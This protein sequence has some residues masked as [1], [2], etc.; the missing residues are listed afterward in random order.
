MN[1]IVDFNAPI[2][3]GTEIVF[4]SPV[5]CSLVT[6]LLVNY[7]GGSQEFAFA[8]A[9]G[10][11]VGD[12]DHL[13]AENVVVKVILDVT[14][15]M[16]FVQNADT[17]AYLEGRFADIEESIGNAVLHTKQTLKE[18][19]KTQAREN[20]GAASVA[21]LP[22]VASGIIEKVCPDF[23][24]SGSVVTC[25]PVGGYPL[26]VAT[27]IPVVAEASKITLHHCGKNLLPHNASNTTQGIT[28]TRDA[29]GTIHLNGTATANAWFY[30]YPVCTLPIVDY[31]LSVHNANFSTG[32]DNFGFKYKDNA[33]N[34]TSL[35]SAISG[36]K[37]NAIKQ[38]DCVEFRVPGGTTLNDATFQIQLE[39]GTVKTKYEPY[40]GETFTANFGALV[41]GDY[42]WQSGTGT[43]T[44]SEGNIPQLTPTEILAFDG[45]NT[46]YTSIENTTTTV[47][48]KADPKAMFEKL[49]NAII[50]LGGNV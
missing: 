11:N 34:V 49:T 13:F 5:D 24:E 45:V 18:E 8:D 17:N 42:D 46:L 1:I 10:N 7:D 31:V 12:I 39:V 48:G 27:F 41:V 50:A 22:A 23:T 43:L 33:H 40:R 20:I 38:I 14:T 28:L 19:Q 3:D 37:S 29:D 36:L 47:S 26:N 21:D 6:G 44:D 16:A 30:I 4:R 2:K 35:D 25:E 32:V 15:S 9:H